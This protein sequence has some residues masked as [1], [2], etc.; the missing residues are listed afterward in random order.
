MGTLRRVG[1]GGIEFRCVYLRIS[2]SMRC[3]VVAALCFQ[4]TADPKIF[5][6]PQ[7]L[8]FDFK[9]KSKK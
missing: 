6:E 2:E 8:N 1:D 5:S 7:S 4:S 9:L 3:W